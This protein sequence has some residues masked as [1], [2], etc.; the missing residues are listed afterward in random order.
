MSIIFT[1][2]GKNFAV[3]INGHF[4]GAHNFGPK[5][6]CLAY[7]KLSED[8]TRLILSRLQPPFAN[9]GNFYIHSIESINETIRLLGILSDGIHDLYVDRTIAVSAINDS[10]ER[11]NRSMGD[12]YDL[13]PTKILTESRY[14]YGEISNYFKELPDGSFLF[15]DDDDD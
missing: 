13:L 14:I 15:T 9:I 2:V 12:S 5:Q 11:F 3:N 7:F 4:F 8:V 6:V 10:I 1:P